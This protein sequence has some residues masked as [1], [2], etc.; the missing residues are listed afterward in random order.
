MEY[1]TR[2]VISLL[3]IFLS[4]VVFP[5]TAILMLFYA[6]IFYGFEYFIGAIMG[7]IPFAIMLRA[8]FL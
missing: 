4:L 5:T 8:H 2:Q 3:L 7:V 1:R 6:G